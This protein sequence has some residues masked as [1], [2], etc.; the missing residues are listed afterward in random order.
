M[1]IIFGVAL[2]TTYLDFG[3]LAFSAPLMLTRVSR[4][5]TRRAMRPGTISGGIRK[6]WRHQFHWMF[7]IFRFT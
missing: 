6:L 1:I 3:P 2:A 5:V 4:S 7:D